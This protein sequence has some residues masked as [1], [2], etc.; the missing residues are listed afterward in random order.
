MRQR[1]HVLVVVMAIATLLVLAAFGVAN[2]LVNRAQKKRP[3]AARVQALW[4]A[5]SAI[6]T[7]ATGAQ[8]LNTA[9]GPATVKVEAKGQKR[10]ATVTMKAGTATA[11]G[12]PG[13]DGFVDFEERYHP[14][15]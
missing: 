14:A 2:V 12:T 6:L 4:L 10:V 7:G 3:D 15:L 11:S 1:G 5:R 9:S 8:T 13:A